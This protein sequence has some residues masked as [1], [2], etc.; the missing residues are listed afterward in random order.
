MHSNESDSFLNMIRRETHKNA[1]FVHEDT[2]MLEFVTLDCMTGVQFLEE[3]GHSFL[4][5]H[6]D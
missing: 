6:L 3:A 4:P 2:L 5:P 1:L